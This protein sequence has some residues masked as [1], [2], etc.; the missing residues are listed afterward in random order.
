MTDIVLEQL[1]K[2]N[3]IKINKEELAK[4]LEK[5]TVNEER[6][7][8]IS[9]YIR[10][11]QIDN[12]IIVQETTTKG[13]ILLRKFESFDSAKRFLNNRMEIYDKMWDGCGC[14]VDYYSRPADK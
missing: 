11:L 1:K 9:D 6:D 5:C 14:K 2:Q 4:L 10:I 3:Y 13:E 7:T 12:N 8:L